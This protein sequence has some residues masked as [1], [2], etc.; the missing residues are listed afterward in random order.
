MDA[1]CASVA[2]NFSSILVDQIWSTSMTTRGFRTLA[3]LLVKTHVTY[4]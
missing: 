1:L 3:Q 2:I 4:Y